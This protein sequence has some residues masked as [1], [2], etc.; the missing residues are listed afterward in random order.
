[1]ID[2]VK[3][4]RQNWK[5]I[6]INYL[7]EKSIL[8]NEYDN[9][10]EFSSSIADLKSPFDKQIILLFDYGKFSLLNKSIKELNL[11]YDFMK[12]YPQIKFKI[13]GYTDS[14]GSDEVNEKLSLNRAKEVYE[15][16]VKKGVSKN[17]LK[18]EGYGASNPIAPNI[19]IDKT[20]NPEGRALNR[21]VEFELFD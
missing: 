5:K 17:R 10:N 13:N 11:L 7:K 16:L 2:W 12:Q 6:D 3:F 18:Y 21:R 15:Y 19:N 20:D 9:E 4:I 14:R 8:L 1:M